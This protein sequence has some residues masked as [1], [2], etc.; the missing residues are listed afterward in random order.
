MN[1]PL[2]LG[3]P[4]CWQQGGATGSMQE[5]RGRQRMVAMHSTA[6]AGRRGAARSQPCS[7]W[8]DGGVSTPGCSAGAVS[9]ESL[10]CG[11]PAEVG[12]KGGNG[13]G[14]ESVLKC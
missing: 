12:S 2:R 6:G 9:T 10:T 8:E 14:E 11:K 4:S 3:N 7:C 13:E 1:S 5:A